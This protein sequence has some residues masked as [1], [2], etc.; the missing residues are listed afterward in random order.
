MS[1]AF[2]EILKASAAPS[3]ARCK[4]RV[5][6]VLITGPE[7]REITLQTSYDPH[8]AKDAAFT[9]FTPSGTMKVS[10]TN[11]NVFHIFEAGQFVYIDVI[12]VPKETT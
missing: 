4:F 9:K 10:V 11:P 3:A 5:E 2:H 6:S 7:N 12:P 8:E 1:Q